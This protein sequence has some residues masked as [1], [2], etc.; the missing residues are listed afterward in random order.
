[1]N[2]R[3][4]T[5]VQI[6]L[7]HRSMT[8]LYQFHISNVLPSPT[9]PA[10]DPQGRV[11]DIRF[12]HPYPR[13]ASDVKQMTPLTPFKENTLEVLLKCILRMAEKGWQ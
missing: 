12:Q 4:T 13:T 2:L 6:T 10:A 11:S 8:L 9:S 3:Q 5:K 7:P 1:M